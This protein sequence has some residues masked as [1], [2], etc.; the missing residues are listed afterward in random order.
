MYGP[1]DDWSAVLSVADGRRLAVSVQRYLEGVSLTAGREGEDV[2][3][4]R[5]YVNR[6]G[7]ESA[8]AVA[9]AGPQ[10]GYDAAE[11]KREAQRCLQCTCLECVKACAY[12]QHY[13]SYP[14]QYVRQINNSLI[15]SPGMGYRASKTMIE[16]CALCGLCAEV[17]PNDLNMGDVCLN[18][19]REL[20]EKGYMPPA[21]HDFALHDMEQ[22]NGEDFAWV[23]HYPGAPASAFAFYPGCQLPASRPSE[24]RAAYE[25]LADRLDGG[26]GLILGCCGAPA[27]WAGRE[28]EAAATAGRLR[29]S[30]EDLGRPRLILACPSCQKQLAVRAPDIPVVSL[31]EVLDGVGLPTGRGA[32]MAWAGRTVAVADPCAARDTPA[33]RT[34]ARSLIA[35]PA[36]RL[37]SCHG[38]ERKLSAAATAACRSSS[39][40]SSPNPR[41]QTAWPKIRMTMWRTVQCVETSLRAVASA[42]ST[43]ST[44]CSEAQR[45]AIRPFRGLASRSGSELGRD[46]DTTWCGTCGVRVRSPRRETGRCDLRSLR[47]RGRRWTTSSS[48]K[49]TSRP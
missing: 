29:T 3:Q 12:L 10:G 30:W 43:S 1:K 48:A 40:D 5:L 45:Q 19:R 4:S 37:L 23:R 7:V 20:V 44:W 49:T 28:R 34:A 35:R 2:A 11:A 15:L 26:V 32:G 18:A 36:L 33:V 6:S 39:I 8:A 47:A 41:L 14:K 13:G 27:E 17:C 16:S 24:V 9:P 46:S 21:V 25:H 38:R 31:W 22:A 42:L